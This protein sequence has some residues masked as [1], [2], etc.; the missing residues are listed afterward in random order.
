MT[1]PTPLAG[2]APPGASGRDTVVSRR[3]LL[4]LPPIA[5][6]A[7]YRLARAA[8]QA[9][10][11]AGAGEPERPSGPAARQ[12]APVTGAVTGDPEVA[13]GLYQTS[14]PDDLSA[15]ADLRARSGQG[16]ALVHWYALWGGWKRDLLPDDLERVAAAGAVPLVTWEPW[17]G[18]A[19]DPAWSLRRAVLSGRHDA[20][21]E[22]WA[23]ALAA[24][25]RPVLL[26]WGHEMHDHPGYPWAVGVNGNTAADFLA[27]WRHLRRIF[28]AFDTSQVQW[29]W[30]P[31]TLGGAPVDTHEAVYRGLYPGDDEV[32]WVGLDVFNT[33]PDLDWGAPYWRPF[34]QVLGT[35]YDALTRVSG[36]LVLLPEVGC[37]ESGGSKAEWIR[38]A[39]T[40][41]LGAR[42]PRLR[43]LVWFDVAKEQPWHLHSSAAAHQAWLM[44]LGQRSAGG[45]SS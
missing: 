15:V 34:S 9:P 17:A 24:Y 20:Y 2:T 40:L 29:I 18:E 22:D 5:V 37:A 21:I 25:G 7:G 1:P 10:R 11:E 43:A 12:V 19:A 39:L 27:A 16:T 38:Q 13:L 36:R 35:P 31:N 23:R 14:F 26:R 28:A 44:A 41:E 6:A 4:A 45:P 30:N 3:L 32:D 33:G 8:A 42:F